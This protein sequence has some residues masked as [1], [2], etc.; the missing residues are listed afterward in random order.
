MRRKLEAEIMQDSMLTS[1]SE[2]KSEMRKLKSRGRR[3]SRRAWRMERAM[4]RGREGGETRIVSQ[5]LEICS[6]EKISEERIQ[7]KGRN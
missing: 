5:I 3:S 2:E 6:M 4:K 7:R 1:G